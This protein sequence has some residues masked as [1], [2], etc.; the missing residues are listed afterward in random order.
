MSL[1]CAVHVG[2]IDDKEVKSV[3]ENVILPR[4]MHLNEI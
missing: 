1:L 4:I 2:L 3:D